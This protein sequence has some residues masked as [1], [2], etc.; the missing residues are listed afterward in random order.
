M[1]KLNP[2]AITKEFLLGLSKRLS[3]RKDCRQVE[4]EVT[5]D[6]NGVVFR[7]GVEV[8]KNR[9]QRSEC[10]KVPVQ[11]M[12]L[13]NLV[14]NYMTDWIRSYLVP[15]TYIYKLSFDR[16]RR[17]WIKLMEVENET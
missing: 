15:G 9:Y 6:E 13:S 12:V 4:Y 5:I 10:D 17:Q 11:D 2:D 8:F 7:P 3:S 1:P 14:N 16:K